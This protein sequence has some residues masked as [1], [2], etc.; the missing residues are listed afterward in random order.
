MRNIIIDRQNS[1]A[2]K[3]QLTI[4]VNFIFFKDAEEKDV[5]HAT[6]DRAIKK[7]TRYVDV[8]EVIDVTLFKISRKFE[9]YQSERVNLF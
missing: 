2:W 9:K 4:A 6:S 7:C 8:N 3:I 5:M 1:D